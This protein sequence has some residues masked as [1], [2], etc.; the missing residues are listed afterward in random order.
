MIIVIHF[1]FFLQGLA[2]KMQV[3][4]RMQVFRKKTFSV[5]YGPPEALNIKI[6]PD[7]IEEKIKHYLQSYYGKVAVTNQSYPKTNNQKSLF[8]IILKIIKNHF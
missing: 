5:K 2:H 4:H 8:L 7:D 6:L 1:I 3:P